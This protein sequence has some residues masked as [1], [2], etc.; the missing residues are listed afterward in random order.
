MYRKTKTKFVKIW[1]ERSY[2]GDYDPNILVHSYNSGVFLNR[3]KLFTF[4]AEVSYL[5]FPCSLLN[6]I[7][8]QKTC[9]KCYKRHPKGIHT[10]D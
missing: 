8:Q 9:L 10:N 7:S 6:P 3:E 5:P 4:Y 1:T 2:A